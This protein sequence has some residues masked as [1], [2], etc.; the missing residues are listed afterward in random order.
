M[1]DK[2]LLVLDDDP[3]IGQ[4]ITSIA[5]F[6]DFNVELCTTPERF[7]DLFFSWSPDAIALDLIMPQ[8]DGVE[9]LAELG[10]LG[11]QAGIIITSGVGSRV[12][13]AASRSAQDKG[14][15]IVGTLAKPFSPKMFRSLLDRCPKVGIRIKS[16][17]SEKVIV[18]Q[19]ELADLQQ[20]LSDRQIRVAYQPKVNCRSGLISGFEA[21]ARLQM[22]GLYPSGYLYSSCRAT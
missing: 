10:K 2:K 11:C 7:F 12:L 8:M 4:T 18:R 22:P 19:F 1:S 20:A 21:L 17:L 6:C 14:L 13:D 3:L 5:Q 9:V 15:N 16:H